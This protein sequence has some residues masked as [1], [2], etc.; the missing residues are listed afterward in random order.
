MVRQRSTKKG[1]TTHQY[2]KIPHIDEAKPAARKTKPLMHHVETKSTFIQWQSWQMV[3]HSGPP[4]GRGHASTPIPGSITHPG[5]G[6]GYFST[7]RL[8][9]TTQ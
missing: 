8:E 7:L 5:K 4:D 3:C 1:L 6:C 9:A 2:L